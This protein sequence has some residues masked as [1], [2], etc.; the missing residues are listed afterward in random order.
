MSLVNIEA[1]TVPSVTEFGPV[2]LEIS[3]KVRAEEGF[4][5]VSGLKVFR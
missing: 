4:R 5:K 3:S 1:P 2:P